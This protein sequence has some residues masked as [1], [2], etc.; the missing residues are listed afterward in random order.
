MCMDADRSSAYFWIYETVSIWLIT[1]IITYYRK[2]EL[3]DTLVIVDTVG[4]A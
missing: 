1:S 2:R 3:R 4:K